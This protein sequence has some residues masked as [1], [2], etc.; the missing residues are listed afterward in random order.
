MFSHAVFS[1]VSGV[2]NSR[3]GR[4]A[5][6]LEDPVKAGYPEGIVYTCQKKAWMDEVKML[7]WIEKIWQPFAVAKDG[8]KVLILDMCASHLTEK[9]YDRLSQLETVPVFIPAGMTSSLQVLDVGI[10]KP[11]KDCLRRCGEDFAVSRGATVI[12]R[13]VDVS[14]WI[15]LAWEGI[16]VE[17]IKR[18]WSH[19]GVMV[20]E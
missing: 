12:P 13:R 17:T 8:V 4:V 20:G 6:E 9:V 5:R 3:T 1:P 7:E 10:N 14:G 16:S 15:K 2:P 18:T 19:I 11:F